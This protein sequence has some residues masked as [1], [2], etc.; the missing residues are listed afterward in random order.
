M[1]RMSE[2]AADLEDLMREGCTAKEAAQ[3]LRHFGCPLSQEELEK[4]GEDIRTQGH[5]EP[6]ES[7]DG[8]FDSAMASAGFGTDESYGGD[9]ERL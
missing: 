4:F 8:D 3:V 9:C 5:S 7:M 1:S 2:L 6:N